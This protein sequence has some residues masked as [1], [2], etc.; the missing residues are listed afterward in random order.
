MVPYN[1]WGGRFWADLAERTGATFVGALIAML[2]A[3][4]SGA[5]SGSPEQWWLLVGLPTLLSLLKGLLRNLQGPEPTASLVG[6][7]SNTSDVP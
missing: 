5:V 4:G 6:V 7:T 2:T 3:D 1:K